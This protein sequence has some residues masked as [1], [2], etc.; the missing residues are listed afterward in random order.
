[1]AASTVC[2]TSRI[3]VRRDQRKGKTMRAFWSGW[4]MISAIHLSGRVSLVPGPAI[5]VKVLL[6][7]SPASP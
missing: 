6:M 1:M 7:M 4:R 5:A 2:M 3:T